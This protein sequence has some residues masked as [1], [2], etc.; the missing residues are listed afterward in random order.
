MES[1]VLKVVYSVYF[2]WW[3]DLTDA[4]SAGGC[5]QQK[6]AW[7]S[8]LAIQGITKELTSNPNKQTPDDQS[9]RPLQRLNWLLGMQPWEQVVLM[10]D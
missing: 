10:Y 5:H 9:W 2:L 4:F 3:D 1:L 7:F 6:S 8:S